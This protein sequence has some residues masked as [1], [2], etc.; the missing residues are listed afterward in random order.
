MILRRIARRRSRVHPQDPWGVQDDD[1]DDDIIECFK[2]DFLKLFV[3]ISKNESYNSAKEKMRGVCVG[4]VFEGF[5]GDISRV[6]DD[7]NRLED[8]TALPT[9]SYTHL[10]KSVVILYGE[11][12]GKIERLNDFVPNNFN[13]ILRGASS[14]VLQHTKENVSTEDMWKRHVIVV[15]ATETCERFNL[16]VCTFNRKV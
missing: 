11:C 13:V 7:Y 14:A 3:N 16:Q 12:F 5:T 6:L 2:N 15:S 9:T 8:C 4:T 10:G 1:N